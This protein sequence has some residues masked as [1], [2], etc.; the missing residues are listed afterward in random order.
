[1]FESEFLSNTASSKEAY[2]ELMARVVE[3][4]CSSLPEN[5]Y[6]G[7]SPAELSALINTSFFPDAG[8]ATDA[9]FGN[10]GEIVSNSVSVSN[11]NTAA[12]LHPSAVAGWTGC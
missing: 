4:V 12:H 8:L 7:K 5:S 1:M 6:R 3:L 2:R 11:P 10:L 9:V